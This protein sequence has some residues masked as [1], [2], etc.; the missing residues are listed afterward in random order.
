MSL[1]GFD[2]EE[3][4]LTL[5]EEAT[6]RHTY[7]GNPDRNPQYF[8]GTPGNSSSHNS[9]PPPSAIT[10]HHPELSACKT[11][12]RPPVRDRHN[13][14]QHIFYVQRRTD[15]CEE[16]A[17]K[18]MMETADLSHFSLFTK[19]ELRRQ[20][21]RV[22]E[23]LQLLQRANSL[24]YGNYNRHVALCLYLV[25]KPREAIELLRDEDSWEVQ[26][27]NGLCYVSLRAYDKA[28]VSFSRANE[29]QRHDS[30]YIALADV[31][32]KQGNYVAAVDTYT[33]ALEFSLDNA[34]ILTELGVTYLRM[35][36]TLRAFA[37]LGSALTADPRNA[38]AILAAASIIQDHDDMDV[39]LVKYRVAATQMDNSGE[40]WNN[41]G[42]CFFGKHKNIAAVACLQR[43]LYLQPFEWMIAYNLGL[44]HLHSGQYASAFRYLS[45]SINFKNDYAPSYM[46]IAI[47]LARMGDSKNA[48]TAYQKAIALGPD[49]QS[50]VVKLNFAI[51]LYNSRDLCSAATQLQDFETEF[52]NCTQDDFNQ[53]IVQR[54]AQLTQLLKI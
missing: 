20:D 44:V 54:R 34:Q 45:A 11:G 48:C 40:L 16:L 47:T 52:V 42:M 33:E 39:A 23:A 15:V 49:G 10:N 12:S 5:P 51:T 31:Y 32:C 29:I 1:R 8:V 3:A 24:N 22:P 2:E 21:G 14:L 35:G 30:T 26:H 50:S 19:A 17:D 25:G 37:S 28:I 18:T 7:T 38:K 46:C 13:W 36:D 53:D 4:S 27:N 9:S 43:A 6:P 41:I